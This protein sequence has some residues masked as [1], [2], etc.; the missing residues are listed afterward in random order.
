MLSGVILVVLLIVGGLGLRW[1]LAGPTGAV[2]QREKTIGD[3]DYRI[4]AYDQFYNLCGDIQAK[5]DQIKNTEERET[6]KGSNSGFTEA[7]KASILLALENS[8]ASLI[9]E[10][11]ADAS[12][13]DTRANFMASDLPYQLDVNGETVCAR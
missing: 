5:E 3:G 6:T 13:A 8:R 10:Y 2:E 11:N 1:V 4:A 7:Q 12:K 9:R